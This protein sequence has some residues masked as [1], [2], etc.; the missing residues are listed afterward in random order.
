M[1]AGG[2]AAYLGEVLA[3]VLLGSIMAEGAGFPGLAGALA[4]EL[5]G[6]VGGVWG[7]TTSAEAR[8]STRERLC[9]G[10]R[11]GRREAAPAGLG[12]HKTHPPGGA[13]RLR[14]G[15]QKRPRAKWGGAPRDE[16][17]QSTQRSC[18]ARRR[19][20][21]LGGLLGPSNRWPP[22]IGFILPFGL[23]FCEAMLRLPDR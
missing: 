21:S 6:D 14:T 10:R 15:P 11:P 1:A 16:A 3:H 9:A 20:D 8:R 12:S 18:D 17:V 22:A 4:V 2:N 19:V 7:A 23:P 5:A 13:R